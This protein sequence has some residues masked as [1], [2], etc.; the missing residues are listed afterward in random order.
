MIVD[1]DNSIINQAE[2]NLPPDLLLVILGPTASGKTSLAVQLAQTLRGEI[3]SIDS[4]QV[5]AGMDIGTGKDLPAYQDIPYH[6]IDI[7][8]P[9]EKYHVSR[10][11]TDFRQAYTQL[12]ARG[13][14]PIACGGTGMYLHALLQDQPYINVPVDHV[15]RGTL[16]SQTKEA[17]ID[18]LI[19]FNIPEGFKI[20]RS[21][22]KRLIRAI[23]ILTYLKSDPTFNLGSEPLK[24]P[25]KIFG[26]D[27][28]TALRRQRISD[29]LAQ[30]LQ[31]GLLE[32]I[33]S[34]LAQ[35]ISHTALQYYGLEY[36]YGSMHLLGELDYKSF[37]AKLET[38]IHRYAKRQMTFYRKM[39]KDGIAI[40]WLKAE[41]T[42]DQLAEI[43]LEIKKG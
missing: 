20:D 40:Q 11:L 4:R 41:N 34:L 5:Y 2:V 38:E 32:E 16:A 10:F 8:S 23:E 22:H 7:C 27:P 31:A 19:A 17:L 24:Y 21:S 18:S 12:I 42:A 35:G 33:E 30:R 37:Y 26:L 28:A 6:L 13:K 25:Y 9:G 3:I 14:Q 39:E 15:L 29:R 43:L 1:I 36:K